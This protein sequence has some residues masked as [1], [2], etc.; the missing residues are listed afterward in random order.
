[1][2]PDL[3]ALLL[4]SAVSREMSKNPVVGLL[5]VQYDNFACTRLSVARPYYADLLLSL[6]HHGP[7]HSTFVWTSVCRRQE[8]FQ[9]FLPLQHHIQESFHQGNQH[10]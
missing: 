4:R 6:I 1:M 3:T 7:I 8:S 5:L 2:D 9:V 10:N